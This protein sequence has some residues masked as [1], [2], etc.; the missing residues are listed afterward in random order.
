MTEPIYKY[1]NSISK[2]PLESKCWRVK[3]LN[4]LFCSIFHVD[5]NKAK[6]IYL[7]FS[8]LEFCKLNRRGVTIKERGFALFLEFLLN[9]K[10]FKQF[11]KLKQEQNF[12]KKVGRYV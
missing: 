7:T 10:E 11:L 12:L 5:K 4:T 1:K 2:S 3:E 6:K 8:E 9:Y